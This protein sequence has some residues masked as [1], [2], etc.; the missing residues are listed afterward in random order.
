MNVGAAHRFLVPGLV[1]MGMVVAIISSLGAPLIPTVAADYHV[2]L[3]E[4][5][6]MLTVVFLV[7][8]VATPLMGRLGDGPRRRATILA[9]LTVVVAGGILAALPLGFGGLLAGRACQGVGLGLTP[10]AITVARDALPAQ[11]SRPAIALLSI[12]TVAGVGL[13]YPITALIA[14]YGGLRTAFWFGAGVAATSLA[15]AAVIVPSSA[16]RLAS[17]LDLPGAAMLGAGLA[18][19]L[20]ALSEGQD[21]GWGSPLLVMVAAGSLAVLAGWALVEVRHSHP[22]VE[23]RLLRRAVVLTAD[24]TG[25]LGGVGMYLMLSVVTRLVQTPVSS[26]YGLG[27]SVAVAGLMLTPFS[28]GSMAAS[29][30]TRVLLRRLPAG[31]V[32]PLGAAVVLAG[33]VMLAFAHGSLWEIAVLMAVAGFGVGAVFGVMPGLIVGSVP[34]GETGSALSFNQ[35]LR[36]IGYSIGS[37]LSA[38]VLQAATAPGHALP[39]A[40]GYTTS[41]LVA[42]GV[43]AATAATA[44]LVPRM[45]PE[46]AAEP[47]REM[48][49]IEIAEEMEPEGQRPGKA[50]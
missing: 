2:S 15:V 13:G 46:W 6:W 33:S 41:G 20:L 11:R 35:V 22:L 43:W 26:G 25:V 45:L 12:T 50:G 48:E 17:R 3:S 40:S 14:Q 16:N 1:F 24:A 8:A 29:S 10:L 42:C 28:A 18:G 30:V 7:S 36:Y 23:L 27:G 44:M 39:A 34:A 4:A 19:L 9:G 5:Q 38:V 37:V 31:H 21:W 49:E 32:L 47:A